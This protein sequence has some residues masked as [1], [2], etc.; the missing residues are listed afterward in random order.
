[1]KALLLLLTAAVITLRATADPIQEYL[2]PPELLVQAQAEVQLSEEQK[3]HL[4]EV[5]EK[6]EAR[7]RDL[8]ERL[9]KENDALAAIVKPAR[10]DPAAALA[11][12]QKVL[13]IDN[14]ARQAQLGFMLAIKAELTPEQQAK[15]TA[16]RKTQDAERAQMEESQKRIV[17]KAARVRFNVERL[18][19]DGGD[20]AP[21]K[22]IMEEVRTLMEKGKIKEA[23]S[24]IDRALKELG[25][26]RQR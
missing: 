22:A 2:F 9:Q 15:L 16:F 14:S 4:Q 18:V 24:A 3:R 11:Q 10:V 13:A 25:D 26:D 12:L 6:M 1:M 23:E 17:A 20:P 7:F 5:T 19:G 8:K 21:I